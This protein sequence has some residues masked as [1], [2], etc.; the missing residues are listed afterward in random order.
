MTTRLSDKIVAHIG[1]VQALAEA[2][3]APPKTWQALHNRLTE[4]R[5]LPTPAAD[6]LCAAILD[7]NTTTDRLAE[8]RAHALA[9][10]AS[11]PDQAVVDNRVAATIEQGLLAAYAKVAAANYAKAAA[12]YDSAAK[13]FAQAVAAID[14]ET[15]ATIVARPDTT[16]EQRQAWADAEALAHQLDRLLGLLVAAAELAHARVGTT[17]DGGHL[18][19][20]CDQVN[21]TSAGY[22]NAGEPARGAPGSGA[23]WSLSV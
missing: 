6:A 17:H 22:G 20:V 11:P 15:D 10:T 23:R 7:E 18:A 19:L 5:Q 4:Y 1:R 2:G 12:Q 8:L 14:P 16:Q 21:A 13:Q 3:I 9:E